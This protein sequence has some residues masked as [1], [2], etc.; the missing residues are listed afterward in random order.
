[1]L[2][3]GSVTSLPFLIQKW[4]LVYLVRMNQR[5]IMRIGI[6]IWLAWKDSSRWQL[7]LVVI[8]M[9]IKARV[10]NTWVSS[11][12][13]CFYLNGLSKKGISTHITATFECSVLSIH[14]NEKQLLLSW[15]K[16]LWQEP[17]TVFPI[18]A[19]YWKRKKTLYFW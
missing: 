4:Y 14:I 19:S 13:K 3:T 17:W 11:V 16:E 15:N 7:L 5:L 12:I 10:W 9:I 1:M 2:V 18:V 6:D 8:P